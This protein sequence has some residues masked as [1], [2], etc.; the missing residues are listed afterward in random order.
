MVSDT[1]GLLRPEARAAL[2][3]VDCILHAGDIGGQEI[4]DALAQVAPVYAIRG[5]NDVGH[6]WAADLPDTRSVVLAGVPLFLIHD[7]KALRALVLPSDVR[8]VVSG[9]SHVP[10]AEMRQ[11]VLYLNPGSAGA[12]RF[13][14]PVSI[15]L[16]RLEAGR[17]R[18]ELVELPIPPHRSR[19]SAVDGSAA[20]EGR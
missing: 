8:V 19:R 12:R 4:L 17:V 5:N 9:H 20:S 11:G 2:R 16:L 18:H 13:R 15:A 1:H 10:K 6:G 7:V 3:G 14:L